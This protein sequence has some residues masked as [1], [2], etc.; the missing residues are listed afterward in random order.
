MRLLVFVEKVTSVDAIV[1]DE[2]LIFLTGWKVLFRNAIT[3]NVLTR[4]SL[5]HFTKFCG[6]VERKVESKSLLRLAQEQ[7]VRGKSRD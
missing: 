6:I 3:I 7:N 1:T 5:V 4:I 2:F